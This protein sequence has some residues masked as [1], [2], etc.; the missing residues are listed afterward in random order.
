MFVNN[1]DTMGLGGLKFANDHEDG[2]FVF[3]GEDGGTG[4]GDVQPADFVQEVNNWLLQGFIVL[5]VELHE[6]KKER[7]IATGK[8]RS[9]G[10]K[11]EI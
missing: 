1:E 2:I 3:A 7:V 11:N 4:G 8:K 5:Q 6:G 10:N 9:K